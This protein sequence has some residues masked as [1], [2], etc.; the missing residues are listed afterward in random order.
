MRTRRARSRKTPGIG[1]PLARAVACAAL[2]SVGT[3]AR[4]ETSRELWP[5]FDAYLKLDERARVFLLATTTATESDAGSVAATDGTVGVHLDYSLT[6]AFRPDLVRQDWAR[7]RYLWTRV[8]YQYVHGL[9]GADTGGG[10]RERR[11]VFEMNARTPPLVGELEWVSRIRWDLRDR[12]GETSS[13][14]RLRLGVERQFNVQ[15]HA[16]VPYLTGE[17]IYDTRFN[18]WKQLRYQAGVEVSLDEAWRIETYLE[19]RN[20]KVAEPTSVRAL[21]V[22]LKYYR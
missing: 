7:N 5:E 10:S 9:G 19:A 8:G 13:L 1:L 11:G 21:G 16:A 17:V 14:Y 12:N 22:A 2:L 15:G 4:P 20:D 3:A 18:E 6:P